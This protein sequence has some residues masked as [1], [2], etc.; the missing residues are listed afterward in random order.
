M[1]LTGQYAP[2]FS[3]RIPYSGIYC[4]FSPIMM[5]IVGAARANIKFAPTS[6]GAY[7]YTRLRASVVWQAN[8]DCSVF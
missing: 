3:F 8:L 4:L 1:L 5:S 2:V 7:S 6:V